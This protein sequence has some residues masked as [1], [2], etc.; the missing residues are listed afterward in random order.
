MKA[1]LCLLSITLLTACAPFGVEPAKGESAPKLCE[2]YGNCS[3]DNVW[4]NHGKNIWG[5]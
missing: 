5:Q 3:S 1:F 2:F 4:G